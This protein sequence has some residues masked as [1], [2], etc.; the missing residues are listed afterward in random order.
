MPVTLR[1][2]SACVHAG[3]AARCRY[4]KSTCPSRIRSYSSAIGS[5]TFRTRSPAAQVS[6]A[7]GV[8]VAPAATYS[9]SLIEEPMPAPVS[10]NTWWPK[11]TSSW[12]PDGVIATRYSWFLTS[13]GI[14]TFTAGA[15]SQTASARRR[16]R[17]SHAVCTAGSLEL[18]RCDGMQHCVNFCP[19]RL[20]ACCRL[21]AVAP[22]DLCSAAMTIYGGPS[23]TRPQ[24]RP[25]WLLLGAAG[26]LVAAILI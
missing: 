23:P 14:A 25:D 8:M 12:T 6:S 26:F 24:Q 20:T 22:A 15:P 13:R 5:L 10:T 7:L 4:V 3:D 17:L 11:L 16:C 2:S 19:R 9:S 18:R 21:P 1:S